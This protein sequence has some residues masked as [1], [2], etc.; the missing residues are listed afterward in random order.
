MNYGNIFYIF[1]SEDVNRLNVIYSSVDGISWRKTE[2]KFLLDKDMTG[3][4][5]PYSIVVDSPYI[6]V[7]FGGDG[8]T[9]AV[10]RGHLNKLM[11]A[12]P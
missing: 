1:G 3:I 2:K 6:W 10:W 5:A 8:K 7:I 11:P 9:N 4:T 12:I